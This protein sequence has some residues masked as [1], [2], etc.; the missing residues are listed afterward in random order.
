V[1]A[2]AIVLVVLAALVLLL[3]IGGFVAAR[4]RSDALAGRL[5]RDVASANE[6]LAAA[7]AEDRGWDRDSID[8]AARAAH[9]ARHA[10]AAIVALHLVQVVDRPGTDDDEAIVHVIDG[11]GEHEIHLGRSGGEWVAKA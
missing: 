10:D 3:L 6:A 2:I 7:R 4:R 8:A 1:S 9:R 5:L 11:T